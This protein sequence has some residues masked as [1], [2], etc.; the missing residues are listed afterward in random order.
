MDGD[1]NNI[2][3]SGSSMPSSAGS[4]FHITGHDNILENLSI[5]ESPGHGIWIGSATA[6]NSTANTLQHLNIYKNHD[7]RGIYIEGAFVDNNVISYDR[8]GAS[9]N[10]TTCSAE[11]NNSMD[12]IATYSS[13]VYGTVISYN[14]I[15]CNG[16][17]GIYLGGTTIAG[18]VSHNTTIE[19]NFIGTDGIHT[20]LGNA[21]NGIESQSDVD[22]TIIDNV[23]SGNTNSGISLRGASGAGI[24]SNRIGTNGSGNAAIPNGKDGINLDANSTANIIGSAT[25][26]TKRNIISGNGMNGVPITGGSHNNVLDGNYIGLG[27][28]G[29]AAIPNGEAGVAI[30]DSDNNA[31]SSYGESVTPQFI[32]GNSREGVYITSSDGTII[33]AKTFIG[34]GSDMSTARGNGLEGVKLDTGTTDSQVYSQKIVYNGGAGVAVIGDT[35]VGNKM[36]PWFVGRNGGLPIDLGNDG[37]TNNGD[38]SPPGP[39]GWQNFPVATL[40]TADGFYGQTCANCEV[41]VFRAVK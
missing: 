3:V 19:G 28:D 21:L 31:L 39:N 18:K 7:G 30:F 11:V 1:T 9:S 41:Y 5:R 13:D 32:S 15:V 24:Y 26:V 36:L 12:G 34:V 40:M 38:H 14:Y 6:G 37:F 25:D 33:N 35:S 20:G 4:I 29:L 8:I 17:G 22:T 16:F 2:T 23:I 27:A 10:S